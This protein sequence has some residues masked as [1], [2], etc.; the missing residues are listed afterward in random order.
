MKLLH[1]NIIGEGERHF[2]IL[3]GFL[4]MGDNWKTHAKNLAE[5][6]YCVHLIDQR[7]HGRSFWSDEFTYPLMA[8]DLKHYMEHHQIKPAILLGHSMGGK[9]AMNFALEYPDL[10]DRLIIADI[11]PKYYAPHHQKILLGLSSLDFDMIQSRKE[12]DEH[13]SSYIGDFGTRQFLLKNLHWVEEGKLGLRVNIE[14][15]KNTGE[16]IGTAITSD[17]QFPKPT[18]FLI[19]GKSTYVDS[20]ADEEL[21]LKYFPQTQIVEIPKAGHWLHAEQ[22][23]VFFETLKSWIG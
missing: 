22:P 13:L 23:G 15:L 10:V 16:A 11:A 19:G 1:A 21:I 6:G 8:D 5:S 2:L 20:S 7:N 4:G 9:T 12:A 14:V 18:L 3:H 17:K